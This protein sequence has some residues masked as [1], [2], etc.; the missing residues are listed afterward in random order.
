MI[1]DCYAVSNHFGSMGFGHYTAFAKNALSGKW[2]EFDDSRV[3][4][5]SQNSLESNIVTNAAYNLFYRRR[6]WHEKNMQDG[7]DYEKMA[8]KPDMDLV[9]KKWL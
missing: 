3:S 8:I 2:Y 1:Y 5:V 9:N 6:D 7:I 4:Q